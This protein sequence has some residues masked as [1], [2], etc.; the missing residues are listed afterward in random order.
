MKLE[1]EVKAPVGGELEVCVA[2]GAVVKGQ[3]LFARIS[4]TEREV[5]QKRTARAEHLCS[6]R[7]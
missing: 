3:A 5:Q 6:S 7:C 1:M 2:A 4:S